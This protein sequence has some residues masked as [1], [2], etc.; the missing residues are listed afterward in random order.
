M[1][2]NISVNFEQIFCRTFQQSHFPL[3]AW[4]LRE[5]SFTLFSVL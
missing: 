2:N 3:F 4:K 1:N 5:C